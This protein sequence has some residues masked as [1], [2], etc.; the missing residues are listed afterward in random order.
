MPVADLFVDTTIMFA[1]I[2]GFTAWLSVREPS[3]V[4]TLLKTLFSAFDEI[5][6]TRRIFEVCC[7]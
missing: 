6:R 4:F 2:V 3:H 5:A 7:S 1:D